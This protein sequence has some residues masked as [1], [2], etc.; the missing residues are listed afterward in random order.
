M[1]V[2]DLYSIKPLDE[3]TLRTA[4]RE[5]PFL[6]TVEDH[7]AAG[8]LGEA[9]L[10]ALAGG[11]GA[12]GGGAA[13]GRGAADADTAAAAAGPAGGVGPAAAPGGAAPGAAAIAQVHILAVRKKPMSGSG[14]ELRDFEGI[15]AKAIVEKV[16]ELRLRG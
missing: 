7:Y 15:S 3:V 10:S 11:P 9:V 5:T 16:K 1:R 2:I 4:A 14:E 6:I 13:G 12:G 8:G